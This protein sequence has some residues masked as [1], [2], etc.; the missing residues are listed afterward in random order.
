MNTAAPRVS[1]YKQSD[2]T[3][4]LKGA[5]AAGMQP[6][7]CRI[8]P[9]G[10]IEVVFSDGSTRTADDITAIIAARKF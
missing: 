7:G 8:A 3:R 5:V 4:A 2:V 9:N 6:S 1:S 10:E